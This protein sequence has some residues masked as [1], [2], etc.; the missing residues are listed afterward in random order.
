MLGL[1]TAENH[2]VMSTNLLTAAFAKLWSAIS[3]NKIMVAVVALGALAAGIITAA[4]NAKK[5]REEARKD[6]VEVTKAYRNQQDSLDS[7]IK[8]YKELKQSL[9]AGSLSANEARSAKEQLL[10]I[11]QDLIESYGEEAC[12][13][14]L[15]NGKYEEQLGLL[16]RMSKKEASDYVMLNRDVFT[17]AKRTMKETRTYSIGPIAELNSDHTPKTEADAKLLSYFEKNKKNLMKLYDLPTGYSQNET[18]I[19][20][21]LTIT[22]DIE[23]AETA[24]EQLSTDL[25][26]FGS[27]NNIDVAPIL[28]KITKQLKTMWTEDLEEYRTVYDEFMRAEVIRDDTLRPLYDRSVTAV[29]NYNKALSSGEDI[30]SAEAE[31]LSVRVSAKNASTRLEGSMDVFND[32]FDLVNKAEDTKYQIEKLLDTDESAQAY[33][34]QLS[35]MTDTQLLALQLYTD[36]AEQGKEA[37]QN[38]L[39]TTGTDTTDASLLVDKLVELGYVQKDLSEESSQLSDSLSDSFQNLWESSSF[40]NARNDL[41]DLAEKAAITKDDITSLAKEN[42]ELAALLEDTGISAQLAASC[43]QAICTET[44][45]FSSITEDARALDQV[46]HGMDESLRQVADSKSEYDLAMRGDDYNADFI[47]YQDAYQNAVE[48]FEKGEFGKHFR[49]NM[50]FLFGDAAMDKD[51]EQLR[52]MVEN[53]EPIFGKDGGNGMGFLDELYKKRDVLMTVAH[54]ET[55]QNL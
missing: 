47:D 14:D 33:A 20:K 39:K 49:A 35:G 36:S 53:L 22:A 26:K 18:K 48:L 11:Q 40:S 27:E 5:A 3:A 45:G 29:D 21:Q 15:V 24:M 46:L 10:G 44:D 12:N 8:K 54:K 1:S 42:A 2:A 7:Q 16:Q 6:A 52:G 9:D 28:T 37:F 55:L 34:Q 4:N 30:A 23:S 17:D 51:L 38:L 43:F 32:I 19:K 41:E 25:E 31:L 13:L 50:R